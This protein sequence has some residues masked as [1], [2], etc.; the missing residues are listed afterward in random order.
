MHA[1]ALAGLKVLD[2]SRGLAGQ[3]ST[4]TLGDQGA[5]IWM[6]EQPPWDNDTKKSARPS[7][8]WISTCYKSTN[9]NKKSIAV[10]LTTPSGISILL[11]LA[12][13][14][15]IIVEDFESLR[16]DI[17]GF[18][19][20]E[21]R[22]SNPRLIHCSI[23]GFG[24]DNDYEER[25]GYDFAIKSE[26][27]L[28]LVAGAH[29][30]ESVTPDVYS[31]D[32]PTG[33]NA[34]QAILAALYVRERTGKGQQLDIALWDTA[35]QM[36]ESIGSSFFTIGTDPSRI[37]DLRPCVALSQT[38]RCEDA[39]ISIKIGTD[40]E[41]YRFC[42]EVIAAPELWV[43]ERFQ[44]K[45]GRK[46]NREILI[47]KLAPIILTKRA[48]DLLKRL[49]VANVHGKRIWS[50]AEAVSSE[51]T[52]LRNLVISTSHPV[53]GKLRTVRSPLRLSDT[54]ALEPAL[55]P[56][57]GEHT[58]SI[59]IAALDIT[60]EEFEGLVAEGVITQFGWTAQTPK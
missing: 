14:V 17:I 16:L 13:Q 15:D 60:K 38:F 53:I 24:R 7:S 11:A 52:T 8:E 46:S 6:I 56:L 29:K 35:V 47:S 21:I 34:V 54:P 19:I 48:D 39:D 20:E 37:G 3:W 40:D 59:L 43:D 36:L 44:T 32:I 42:L 4:M 9:R 41:Y 31:L 49:E 5:E 58:L 18:D 50:V 10:D 33:M 57:V 51:I 30:G 45:F 25:A 22:Q 28:T 55:T 12:E 23:T 2:L 26:S 27:G 1:A